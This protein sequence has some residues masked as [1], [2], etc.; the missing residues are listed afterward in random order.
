MSGFWARISHLKAGDQLT[1]RWYRRMQPG[2]S[3]TYNAANEC[4]GHHSLAARATW[5]QYLGTWEV[6]V[7]LAGTEST[8][9]SFQV[10]DAGSAVPEI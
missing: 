5:S 6:S 1:F 3:S 9:Q 2:T 10:V 7:S 4:Y 8:R